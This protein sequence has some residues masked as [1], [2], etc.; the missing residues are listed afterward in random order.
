MQK[1]NILQVAETTNSKT[2]EWIGQEEHCDHP[3]NE[4]RNYCED[5]LWLIY[6]KGTAVKVRKPKERQRVTAEDIIVELQEIYQEL[7]LSG[8]IIP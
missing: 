3:S 6:Q 8:K 2:C 5:H 4:G 1:S 7:L